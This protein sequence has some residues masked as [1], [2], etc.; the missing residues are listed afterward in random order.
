MLLGAL[1][2]GWPLLV[3]LGCASGFFSGLLGI[4]G[5]T[6]LVPALVAG[7]PLLGVEGPEVVKIA[8]ATS[9]ALII[10]TSIAATQMHLSKAAVDW[11]L[12]ALLGPSIIAG[13]F[14]A[15]AFARGINVTVLSGLFVA[16][17]LYTAWGL[18][19]RPARAVHARPG[20]TQPG[21]IRITVTGVL[22][23]ALSS[24]LGLGV[25]FFA[26]PVMARFVSMQTA[27]GTA[28]AL[29]IPM[30]LAGIAGYVLAGAPA[31]CEGCAGYIFLPAVAAIGISAVLAAPIGARLTHLLPV[32]LLRRLFGGLLILA[33]GH[34]ALKTLPL[35]SV[36]SE[37]GKLLARL[38]VPATA[39]LPVAA[40][41][42]AGLGEANVKPL[43]FVTARG[44]R[45]QLALTAPSPKQAAIAGDLAALH[46]PSAEPNSWRS[47]VASAR[48][49]AVLPPV[50]QR[51]NRRSNLVPNRARRISPDWQREA[52]DKSRC[53]TSTP[54]ARRARKEHD[55]KE[56]GCTGPALPP[57]PT[58]TKQPL[59][60]VRRGAE[61][62]ALTE[63]TAA[64]VPDA[65]T[66]P[67][68]T[69]NPFS[70]FSTPGAG[71]GQ[72]VIGSQ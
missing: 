62:P 66:R 43:T 4:G 11:R 20:S 36:P 18:M 45:R 65:E 59:S 29:G 57:F 68:A 51:A 28:A 39:G 56:E 60:A 9:L 22:G 5:G 21:L 70:E 42:P 35:A 58:K 44:P 46:Q 7:L 64:P 27:I 49:D 24:L 40:E 41:P 55:A 54:P 69:F 53:E 10:P 19:R 2:E 17:A 47:S 25:A 15:A 50:P 16:F 23:G 48:A 52:A 63:P 31:G 1:A 38:T 61:L 72:T 32:I 6:I 71:D 30:A 37:A 8:M 67:S 26:V 12:L 14:V 13:S 33:A 34:L 3:A